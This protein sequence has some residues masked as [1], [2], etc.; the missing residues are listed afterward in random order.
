M[1]SS[2]FS[3]NLRHARHMRRMTQEE[4][5]SRLHI[6]RQTYSNYETGKRLPTA[7]IWMQLA[8]I[9][10]VPAEYFFTGNILLLRYRDTL[11]ILRDIHNLP[12]RYQKDILKLLQ[13]V[14]NTF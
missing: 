11:Q 3:Q 9:L 13:K 6:C 8:I 2:T 4:V 1:N 14:Q 10:E 7:D 12:I 5:S